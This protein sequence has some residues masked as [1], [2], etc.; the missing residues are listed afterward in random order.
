MRIK[1]LMSVFGRNGSYARGEVVDAPEAEA[2]Q[3][4][5]RGLATRP[6][7]QGAKPVSTETDTGQPDLESTALAGPEG[8]AA[9]P[10][11]R[12]ERKGA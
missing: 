1:M 5:R 6:G 9:E 7:R 4:I 3:L 11:P 12:R 2:L 8:T 10:K